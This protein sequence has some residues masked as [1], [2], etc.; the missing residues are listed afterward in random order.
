MLD[1]PFVQSEVEQQM[2][3]AVVGDELIAYLPETLEP[4]QGFLHSGPG[5]A[6]AARA[7]PDMIEPEQCG[8]EVPLQVR[9]SRNIERR[10]EV[11]RG[12]RI[13]ADPP[14][15]DAGVP[16]HHQVF[17]FVTLVADATGQFERAAVTRDRRRRLRVRKVRLAAGVPGLHR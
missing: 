16:D 17:G 14:G 15:P 2:A 4:A 8:A 6:V 12:P 10:L 5:L 3:D 11:C 1:R 7:G 9:G 13:V